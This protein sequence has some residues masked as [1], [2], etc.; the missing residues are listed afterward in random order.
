MSF[1]ILPDEL[2]YIQNFQ[3]HS[4]LGLDLI[5]RDDHG[6][7]LDPDLT[8]TIDL[9]RAHEFAM[10]RIKSNATKTT[11]RVSKAANYIHNLLV[12][13][14]N[15]VCRIGDDADLI[16]SLFD[17]REMKLISE[18]YLIK[19][20]RDGLVKDLDLLNNLNVVF[21]VRRVVSNQ[22]VSVASTYPAGPRIKRYAARE[23]IFCVSSYPHRRFE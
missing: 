13:V 3:F 6:C 5:V 20:G 11:D 8:S 9:F 12:T 4:L 22:Q 7:Q 10:K 1:T 16:V 18:N 17:G 14:R 23:N 21:T 19:W 2:F 15:F